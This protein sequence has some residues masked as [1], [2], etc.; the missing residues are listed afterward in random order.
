MLPQSKSMLYSL[1]RQVVKSKVAPSGWMV[2]FR[3]EYSMVEKIKLILLKKQ[4][5]FLI[6]IM[7][8]FQRINV[9][10]FIIHTIVYV[11]IAIQ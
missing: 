1:A 10:I 7:I 5:L 3:H 9:Y 4:K 11:I 8:V 2:D 6:I